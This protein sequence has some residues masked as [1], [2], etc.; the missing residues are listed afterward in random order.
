VSALLLPELWPFA[1]A[2]GLMLAVAAM[3][4]LTLLLG[5]SASHWLDG[6]I[7]HPGEPDG[8]VSA[9]LGWLHVGKVPVLAILVMFMTVFAVAGFAIQLAMRGTTGYFLP[10]PLAVG[11]AAVGG[12]LAVRFLGSAL[13][14]LIP[15]DESTAVAD[16]SLV[17]RVAV[18]VIGAA[19]AGRPAE[20]RTHDE[21]A[22]AHYVMVEPEEPGETFEKG[23]SVLLVRHL[24]GRRYHAI[25]NPRPGLL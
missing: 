20:A 3:E 1:L 15:K 21:H 5:A 16:A 6:L 8:P 7:D 12:V 23:T 9:A 22:A 10:L 11:V 18:V 2:T 14:R 24:N 17:G 4:A 13:G 19:R 25:R